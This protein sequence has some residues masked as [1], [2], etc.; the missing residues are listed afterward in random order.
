VEDEEES[1]SETKEF[2]FNS[3]TDLQRHTVEKDK[4]Q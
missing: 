4:K 2:N 3:I 1:K